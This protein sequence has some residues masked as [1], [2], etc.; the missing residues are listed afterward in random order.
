MLHHMRT[1]SQM[2]CWVAHL[3]ILFE[4]FEDNMCLDGL[5]IHLDTMNA[6]VN[7]LPQNHHYS[8]PYEG[9]SSNPGVY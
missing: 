6:A 7:V 5:S 1:F 2:F 8:S 9:H 3:S 4:K